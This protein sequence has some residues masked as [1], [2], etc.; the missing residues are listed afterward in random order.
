[1]RRSSAR[2]GPTGSS[3]PFFPNDQFATFILSATIGR[4]RSS[5]STSCSLSSRFGLV[6]SSGNKP[7]QYV[8][9]AV[10]VATPILGFYGALNPAPHDRSNYNWVAAAWTIGLLVVAVIWFAIVVVAAA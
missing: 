10:A 5:S 6:R 3:C 1:M 2:R 7:W 9:V 4:S 8:I